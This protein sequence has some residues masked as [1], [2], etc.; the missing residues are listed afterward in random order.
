MNEKQFNSIL[1]VALIPEVVALIVDKD[2]L[3]DLSAVNEFYSSKTYDLLTVE[4]T[5]MWHYSPLTIYNIYKY[6]K[7]NGEV[8]FPEECA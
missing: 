3:D 4:E 5:K 6:E 8:V 2:G 1:S 7:E